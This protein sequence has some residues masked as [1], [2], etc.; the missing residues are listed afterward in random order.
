MWRIVKLVCWLHAVGQS[1]RNKASDLDD[2]DKGTLH[3]KE[4]EPVRADISMSD[5]VEFGFSKSEMTVSFSW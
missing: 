1:T 2:Q 3:V 5:A 4:I